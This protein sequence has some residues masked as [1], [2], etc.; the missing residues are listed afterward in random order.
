M[1]APEH[2]QQPAPKIL[3]ASVGAS[4]HGH[5][6]RRP[7]S[8]R[9]ATLSPRRRHLCGEA[10][11]VDEHELGRIEIELAVEPVPAP[12]QDVGAIQC[13]RGLF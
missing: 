8:A 1:A 6:A 7:G 12:L 3:L 10:G 11:L 2:A 13:V 9:R 5:A 4:T